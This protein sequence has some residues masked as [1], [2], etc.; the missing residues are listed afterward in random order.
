MQILEL[1]GHK[2][3]PNTVAAIGFFDGVHKAHQKLIN[4]MID[5]ADARQMK[6]AVITFDVHPKSVLFDLDYRYITP[7]ER[8]IEVL[9]NYD[10]DYLYIIRFD[11]EKAKMTPDAFIDYYLKGLNTLVCGFDFKFGVRASGNIHT[12]M[13]VDEFKTIM[14]EEMRYQ[15]Y[16]IG[17]THIRDLIMS[18]QVDEIEETLGRHYSIKGNVIHG[19]KKGR[20]IGYPTANIDTD[21]Y[22]VPRQGVYIS[23]TKVK[24][25]WHP[26]LSTI[27]Y[28][29]TLNQYRGLSTESYIL[30]FDEEIYEEIIEMRF[31]KRLRCEMTF[32]SKQALIDQIKRDEQ[33]AR[34]FFETDEFF[35]HNQ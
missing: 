8:K 20:E 23:Y 5:V 1:N 7:F 27:G 32:H 25:K 22:L 28:N 15:G 34:D 6:R 35:L 17:S 26:S 31:V 29:P 9:S 12:L 13:A 18:G 16:K 4:T 11:K 24:D 30:D 10:L 21:G 2:I 19:Q 14:V 3:A 33:A